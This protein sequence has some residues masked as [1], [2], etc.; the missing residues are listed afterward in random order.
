MNTKTNWKTTRD[1]HFDSPEVLSEY[2]KHPLTLAYQ[3][4]KPNSDREQEQR[5]FIFTGGFNKPMTQVIAHRLHKSGETNE[6]TPILNRQR[7]A[8]KITTIFFLPNALPTI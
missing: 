6:L 5:Y 4:L 8:G 7:V 1:A 3:I 2:S